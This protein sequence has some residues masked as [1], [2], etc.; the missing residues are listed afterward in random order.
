MFFHTHYRHK[1][2]VM[3][4]ELN[5]T[6]NSHVIRNILEALLGFITS[7][8]LKK[9]YKQVTDWMVEWMNEW[10]NERINTD[11]YFIFSEVGDW[12]GHTNN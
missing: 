12:I 9:P 3:T 2:D 1:S 8:Q 6:I 4:T 11:V 5:A 7:V 10:M